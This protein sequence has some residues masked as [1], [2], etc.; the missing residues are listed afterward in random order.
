MTKPR[1]I[2]ERVFE[3]IRAAHGALVTNL[4]RD[5][6]VVELELMIKAQAGLKFD[7]T[8]N[9]VGD[10]LQLG[11]GEFWAS[12]FPCMINDVVRQYRDAVDGLLSGRYRILEYRRRGG[13]VKAYLQ[14]PNGSDW[15]N[16]AARYYRRWPFTWWCTDVRALQNLPG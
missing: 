11:A 6:G 13:L 5:V 1:E 10:E 15:Q 3:E 12:W 2:A 7:V 8:L 14:R 4:E 16:V 9:L